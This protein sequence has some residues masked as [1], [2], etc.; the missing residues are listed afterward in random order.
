MWLQSSCTI[1][2]QLT[3][4]V[5]VC[6]GVEAAMLTRAARS[7]PV[8][9]HHTVLHWTARV[10]GMQAR[11]YNNVIYK[12]V[13]DLIHK[14]SVMLLYCSISMSIDCSIHLF[15]LHASYSAAICCKVIVTKLPTSHCRATQG[16]LC[17]SSRCQEPPNLHLTI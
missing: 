16:T 8:I 5:S 6:A 3:R 17:C 15:F 11:K 4:V 1:V 14:I 9:H 7:P 12:Y 2:I 13:Q 10:K